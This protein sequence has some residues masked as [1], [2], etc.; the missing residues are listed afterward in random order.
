MSTLDC[1]TRRLM[2]DNMTCDSTNRSPVSWGGGGQLP[3]SDNS[4]DTLWSLHQPAT[5][6]VWS[7][8][9]TAPVLRSGSDSNETLTHQ[10]RRPIFSLQTDTREPTA[11]RWSPGV[12]S[13]SSVS[14][15]ERVSRLKWAETQMCIPCFSTLLMWPIGSVS[16]TLCKNQSQLAQK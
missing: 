8:V 10:T 16:D 13:S 3:R 6:Y 12:S 2:N 1:H 9:V 4:P 14:I 11:T 7:P 15:L 5:E